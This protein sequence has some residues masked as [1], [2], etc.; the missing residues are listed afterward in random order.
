ML[1]C[2]RNRKSCKY[3][4]LTIL[5]ELV[6]K[7]ELSWEAGENIRWYLLLISRIFSKENRQVTTTGLLANLSPVLNRNKAYI[8]TLV[9]NLQAKKKKKK[10]RQSDEKYS[11]IKERLN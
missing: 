1:I 9:G 8:L 7:K 10:K 4:N 5:I 11:R 6:V 2:P 3:Y